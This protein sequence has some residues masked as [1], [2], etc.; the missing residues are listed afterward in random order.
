MGG[1]GGEPP[2]P[3]DR[4]F[5][6]ERMNGEFAIL[7]MGSKAVI[8]HEQELGPI[9]DRVRILTVEAFK[10]L[11]SNRFTEYVDKDGKLKA[12]PWPIRW[13]AERSR[14]QYR[15]IESFRTRMAQ[16]PHPPISTCGAASRSSPTRVLASTRSSA[17]TCS[18]TSATAAKS[19]TAGCLPSSR[20]W[21]SDPVSASVRPSCSG[22]PGLRQDQDGQVFGSLFLSHYFLVDDLRT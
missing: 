10:Q 9:E 14:R 15:G 19:F 11:W 5:D 18:R 22:V 3:P 6:L 21:C 4:G 13:L 8:L 16:R 1:E 20:T 2:S 12:V 17:T 7:P